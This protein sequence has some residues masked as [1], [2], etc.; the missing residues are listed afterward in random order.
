MVKA[1]GDAE[2]VEHGGVFAWMFA[3]GLLRAR[4]R[5][6]NV[7]PDLLFT[8]AFSTLFPTRLIWPSGNLAAE[9]NHGSLINFY[10]PGTRIAY[11]IANY[12]WPNTY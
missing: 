4:S 10:N 2:L 5:Y 9:S 8:P 3:L 11:S 1:S 7:R 6:G 12:Q